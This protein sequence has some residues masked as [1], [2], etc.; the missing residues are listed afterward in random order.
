MAR[1]GSEG[2]PPRVRPAGLAQPSPPR[3]GHPRLFSRRV[4]QVATLPLAPEDIKTKFLPVKVKPP[5]PFIQ[6]KARGRRVPPPS[7]APRFPIHPQMSTA[8]N[9]VHNIIRSFI[10]SVLSCRNGIICD[11]NHPEL[12]IFIPSQISKFLAEF[13]DC[14]LNQI[15]EV[16]VTQFIFAWTMMTKPAF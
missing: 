11:D 16:T 5:K 6:D 10:N 1:P 2:T 12:T 13:D 9:T 15:F 8:L 7:G 14:M 3:S 4:R